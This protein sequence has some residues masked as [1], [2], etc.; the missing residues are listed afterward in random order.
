MAADINEDGRV[1]IEDFHLL[2]N[3]QGLSESEWPEERQWVFYTKNSVDI[4]P[5]PEEHNNMNLHQSY[6]INRLYY[7]YAE[8]KHFIGVLKGD[9]D[10]YERL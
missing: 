8:N 6:E 2:V 5:D 4:M 9:L 1:D 10:Y 3:L 7:G